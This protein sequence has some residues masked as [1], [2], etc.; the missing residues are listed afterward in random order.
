M[1]RVVIA[2]GF[3]VHHAQG[4]HAF[5]ADYIQAVDGAA[6]LYLAQPFYG[7]RERTLLL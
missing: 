5:F 2:A 3:I 7:D 6:G 4:L 1:R